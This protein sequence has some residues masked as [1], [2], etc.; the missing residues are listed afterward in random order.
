M[1]H[2]LNSTFLCILALLATVACDGDA[3]DVPHYE[4]MAST[5]VRPSNGIA[6]IEITTDDGQGITD[7]ATWKG[8]HISVYTPDTEEATLSEPAS[9]KGRGN[10]TFHYTKKAFT[11][12]FEHKQPLL[13]MPKAKKWVFLAN[14]RDPTLLRNDFTFGIARLTEGLEWTPRGEFA[15]VVFN[16]NYVGN[17][18]VCEKI[19]VGSHRVNIDKLTADAQDIT[20][21]YLLQFD[22]TFDEPNKF[23][24]T[25]MELPVG[26]KS[27]DA[28]D[29]TPQH[30]AYIEQFL[31]EAE[32]LLI[33]HDFTTLYD[34]YI[35]LPSFVDFLL[36]QAIT[37]NNDFV[38]PRSV[39]AYKKRG[40]K[41]FAGPVWDFDFSTYYRVERP[42]A[43][44]AWWYKHLLQ[45]PIFCETVKEHWQRLRPL[46]DT[47]ALAY[48]AERRELI[49]ESAL[50]NFQ[51]FPY[52]MDVNKGNLA[53]CGFVFCY[54][55]LVSIYL[56]HLLYLDSYIN[57]L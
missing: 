36:V 33:A 51:T 1:T 13:G 4:Q 11:L 41:L 12:K 5:A 52:D 28:N 14:Y 50:Q 18:F 42:F 47:E 20:G 9:F 35:D 10:S 32:S 31:N 37:G 3:T 24:T 6:V 2:R 25:R 55:K 57:A 54:E 19:D 26:I 17:Y 8:G 30:I 39:Y 29:C 7:R 34:R 22:R 56:Q 49:F 43:G 53:D 48:L 16:G 15:D 45:D 27:P 23:K 38:S 21:G 44:S 46:L 40:G